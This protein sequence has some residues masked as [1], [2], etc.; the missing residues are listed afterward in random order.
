METFYIANNKTKQA[1]ILQ[2]Y[3]TREEI[4]QE[5]DNSVDVVYKS[6]LDNLLASYNK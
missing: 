4:W 2:T 5:M 1:S 3:K 6:A